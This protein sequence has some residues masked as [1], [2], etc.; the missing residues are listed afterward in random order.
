MSWMAR[1]CTASAYVTSGGL[2]SRAVQWPSLLDELD[3]IRGPLEEALDPRAAT[4][5]R[6]SVASTSLRLVAMLR[7][8]LPPRDVSGTASVIGPAE[9]LRSL[10]A[11]VLR[12]VADALSEVVDDQS[13]NDPAARAVLVETADAAQA[14]AR[15]VVSC[16]ALE[17]FSFDPVADPVRV[18]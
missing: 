10:V 14:W 8:Q 13:L 16:R 15:T 1:R 17:A 7:A 2:S 12:H 3:T 5:T 4:L 9:L 6:R 11:G 18:S